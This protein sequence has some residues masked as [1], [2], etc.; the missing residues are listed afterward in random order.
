MI[1]FSGCETD[2]YQPRRIGGIWKGALRIGPA[3]EPRQ[4]LRP[5]D[6]MEVTVKRLDAGMHRGDADAQRE[7]TCFSPSP[8]SS[9][10][11][12]CRGR[13]QWQGILFEFFPDK[14]TRKYAR[15][16]GPRE[17]Q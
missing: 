8:S 16:D 6:D 13:W 10:I 5:P 15:D 12:V 2:S 3:Q 14:S 17:N 1:R 11:G 9:H 7:A 4:Q